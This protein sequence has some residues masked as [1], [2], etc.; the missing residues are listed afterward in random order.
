[1]IREFQEAEAT[2]LED[3]SDELRGKQVLLS[4]GNQ[5]VEHV[6]LLHICAQDTKTSQW[7]KVMMRQRRNRGNT[8]HSRRSPS[9]QC[10]IDGSS[11]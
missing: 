2:D 4:L 9:S 3:G 5:R 1:M 7:P 6:L 8:H 10:P 11:R